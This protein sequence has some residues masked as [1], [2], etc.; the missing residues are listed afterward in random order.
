MTR[1]YPSLWYF[2]Y[3]KH[4][5][6]SAYSPLPL[7]TTNLFSDSTVLLFIGYRIL[8]IIQYVTFLN[9]L[10]SLNNMHLSS[11]HVFS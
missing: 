11:L 2:H 3:P 9:W 1:M 10:L 4:P 6:Y 5:M 7:V 8:G